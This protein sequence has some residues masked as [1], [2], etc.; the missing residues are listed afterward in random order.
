[1]VGFWA[2]NDT[3]NNYLFGLGKTTVPG[4]KNN[5]WTLVT[6]QPYAMHVVSSTF[7]H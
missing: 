3:F 5:D 6:Y 2:F 7:R 4:G 1:M